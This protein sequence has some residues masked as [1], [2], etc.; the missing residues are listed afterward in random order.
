MVWGRKGHQEGS[1]V[2]TA[3]LVFLATWELF[4]LEELIKKSNL[5]GIWDIIIFTIT[6]SIL[7]AE[8]CRT[9][10]GE[11]GAVGNWEAPTQTGPF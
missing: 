10:P 9:G 7:E 8:S 4:S 11:G 1:S 5:L 2:V 3:G 6:H